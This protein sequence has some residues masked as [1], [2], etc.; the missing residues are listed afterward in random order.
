MPLDS[1]TQEERRPR[2]SRGKSSGF[3]VFP[4]VAV[5][6]LIAVAYFGSQM[7]AEDS[8]PPPAKEPA[9]VP[10]A[11]VEDEAPPDPSSR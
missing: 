10:F 8:A 7:I 11:N 4:A 6:A 9:Y 3:P 1:D 5:F 2:S